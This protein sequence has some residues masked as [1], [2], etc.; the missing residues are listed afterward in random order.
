MSL[1]S[2]IVLLFALAVAAVLLRGLVNMMLGG[3]ANLS[4]RLM[5]LRV[6]LQFLAILVVMGVLWLRA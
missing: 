4:Q 6:A 5:R 2:F 3:D 1:S